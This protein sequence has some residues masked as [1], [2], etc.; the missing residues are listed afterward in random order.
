M[1]TEGAAG[2][3]TGGATNDG[4][5]LTGMLGRALLGVWV[6]Y[7]HGNAAAAVT[8]NIRAEAHDPDGTFRKIN[9]SDAPT[10]NNIIIS[11]AMPQSDQFRY[12]MLGDPTG[13][14]R[15]YQQELIIPDDTFR[16]EANLDSDAGSTTAL[17]LWVV[18][19]DGRS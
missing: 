7:T 14:P 12:I 9:S 5:T 16:L 11:V 6:Q 3:W 2:Q 17:A 18:T 10:S 13:S 4:T 8:V 19:A 1:S 15:L